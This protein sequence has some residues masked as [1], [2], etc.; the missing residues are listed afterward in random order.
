MYVEAKI[1]SFSGICRDDSLCTL[2]QKCWF[3]S[4]TETG[5][6]GQGN[7]VTVI[8]TA[9]VIGYVHKDTAK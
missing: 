5:C 1:N 3:N 4:G 2:L 6:V 9:I 8:A 7:L